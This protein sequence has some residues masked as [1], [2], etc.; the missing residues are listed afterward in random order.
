MGGKGGS[1]TQIT[2][3][4]PDP[5]AIALA[6]QQG[7]QGAELF[8]QSAGLRSELFGPPDPSGRG[9][10]SQS[11]N[12]PP[13]EG[14][15][16]FQGRAAPFD[17]RAREA[18][19]TQFAGARQ[20]LGGEIGRGGRRQA[21]FQDLEIGRAQAIGRQ[22][23]EETQRVFDVGEQ[24]RQSIVNAQIRDVA[25]RE[26]QERVRTGRIFQAATPVLGQTQLGVGA[27]GQAGA[28]LGAITTGQTTTQGGGAKDMSGIGQA[29]GMIGKAAIACWIAHAIYGETTEF[30]RAYEWINFGWKGRAADLT[31]SVY[32]LIGPTLSKYPLLCRPLKPLFDIAVRKGG[33]YRG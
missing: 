10:I 27:T 2:T 3:P 26:E 18:I 12:I 1:T 9:L 24:N 20:R 6:E 8:A 21:A 5:R 22:T 28:T 32:R 25:R 29:V 16:T 17:P 30:L 23:Q 11:F 14:L 13:L 7:G 4:T 33:E 31:R 15:P 19:E